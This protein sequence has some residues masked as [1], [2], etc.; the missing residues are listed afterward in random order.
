MWRFAGS[1]PATP[2]MNIEEI[3]IEMSVI[4]TTVSTKIGGGKHIAIVKDKTANSVDVFLKAKTVDGV[5][6]TQWFTI[7]AFNK[8][9]KN[10]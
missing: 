4:D 1:N 8:R 10:V 3:E 5:D 7:E 2:T 6:C 9:F